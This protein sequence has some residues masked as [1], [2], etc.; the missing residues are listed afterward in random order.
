MANP[1]YKRILLKLS[2]EALSNKENILNFD[3]IAEVA[4]VVKKCLN[5]GVEIAVLVGGGNIWR[6]GRQD[7]ISNR[8]KADSMGM[9]AT[10]INS[11]A[12]QEAFITNGINAI[13]MT[14]VEMNDVAK[15]Y[16]PR[17]AVEELKKGRVVILGGGTGAPFFSTDTAAMLRGAEIEADVVL[18]AKNVDGVYTS[19]PNAERG[20]GEPKAV[21]YDDLTY[22]EI[23]VKELKAID[24]TAAAFGMAN[25]IDSYV[26]DLRDP[27][28]IYRSVMGESVGTMLH[29]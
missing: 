15:L 1:K 8:A 10:V 17:D 7:V 16:I 13:A 22:T 26:F 24:L 3:F 21:R 6:G 14:S 12:L 19:D 23:L 4:S 9:L 25:N 20:E 27:M 28:N 18:M 11:I 5:E 2:G 29:K